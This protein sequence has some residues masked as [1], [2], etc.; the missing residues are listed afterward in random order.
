MQ[1]TYASNPKEIQFYLNL[2]ERGGAIAGSSIT[3]MDVQGRYFKLRN[4]S[5]LRPRTLQRKTRRR[6]SSGEA[7]VVL[8]RF[9]HGLRLLEGEEEEVV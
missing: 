6:L 4:A 9:L 5:V 2:F 1:A 8:D 7:R 3:A